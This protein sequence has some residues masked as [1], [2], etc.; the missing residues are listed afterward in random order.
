MVASFGVSRPVDG[1]IV[2]RRDVS[3]G[4]GVTAADHGSD[5]SSGAALVAGATWTISGRGS[6][7]HFQNL[8][9]TGDLLHVP[10]KEALC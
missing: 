5:L 8:T 6:R 4:T 7:S 3:L 2:V 10:R 1:L 9:G